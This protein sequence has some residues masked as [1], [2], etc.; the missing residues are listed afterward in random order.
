MAALLKKTHDDATVQKYLVKRT[1]TGETPLNVALHEGHVECVLLLSDAEDEAA[2]LALIE[3]AKQNAPPERP[4]QVVDSITA[5]TPLNNDKSKE[6]QEA[7]EIVQQ[8]AGLSTSDDDTQQSLELKRQ[9]NEYFEKKEWQAAF[10]FYTKAIALNPTDA[11]FYSNR[12]A[13]CME[14]E[15]Y[16]EALKDAVVARYIRPDWS[17]ACYRMAV[18]RMALGRYEDAAVSAFEALN[19]DE[20]NEEIKQ[21]LREAVKKGQIEYHAQQNATNQNKDPS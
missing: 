7:L 8:L 4:Q 17:K 14:L 10:D 16:Q 1:A 3:T 21:L 15:L 20:D 13:C 18:A 6:E 11:S 5:T 19:C 2:A 12:S 9:G